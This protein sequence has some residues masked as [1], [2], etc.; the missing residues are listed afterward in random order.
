MQKAGTMFFGKLKGVPRAFR[1]DTKGL[2]TD[3]HVVNRTG[4]RGEI[5]NKIDRAEVEGLTDIVLDQLKSGLIRKVFEV[6]GSTGAEV[7]DSED[8]MAF[9]EERIA[10]MRSQKACCA[11]DQDARASN[12][13][14]NIQ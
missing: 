11:G 3:P 13:F 7:V 2:D 4:R 14:P 8:A 5:E 10:E 1:S 9:C 12:C 6:G